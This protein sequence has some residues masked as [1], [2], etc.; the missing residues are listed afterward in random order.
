M[1]AQ[2]DGTSAPN[3]LS[4]GYNGEYTGV[5]AHAGSLPDLPA[6]ASD[7][8]DWVVFLLAIEPAAR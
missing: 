6:T 3:N 5:A 8:D 7:A 1:W 2:V 4:N